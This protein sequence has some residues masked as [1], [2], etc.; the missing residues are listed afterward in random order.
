MKA[1]EIPSK[2][3]YDMFAEYNETSYSYEEIVAT[4]EEA[5][6]VNAEYE[7]AQDEAG[8][9]FDERVGGRDFIF[10]SDEER[11][12]GSALAELVNESGGVAAYAMKGS[13]E[14]VPVR[15]IQKEIKA[16]RKYIKRINEFF[17]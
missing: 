5:N 3:L 2:K 8:R 14:F 12:L 9:K 6:A 10:Q 17:S 13:K 4:I 1:I 7:A 11:K 15:R 16:T